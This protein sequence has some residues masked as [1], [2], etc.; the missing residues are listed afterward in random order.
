MDA[1]DHNGFEIDTS[2]PNYV[3]VLRAFYI[4]FQFR[5]YLEIGTSVGE[6]LAAVQYASSAIDPQLDI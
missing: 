3:H 2:A 5:R 4:T 6:S 1:S